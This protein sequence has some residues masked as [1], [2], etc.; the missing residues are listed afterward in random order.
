MNTICENNNIRYGYNYVALL[1]HFY[2][3]DRLLRFLLAVT[4]QNEND[5]ND[6]SNT[7]NYSG[8]DVRK[9]MSDSD[10]TASG[11]DS[12]YQ[13]H[14]QQSDSKVYSLQEVSKEEKK[15]SRPLSLLPPTMQKGISVFGI[16]KINTFHDG[17]M[18]QQ[19]I[20][21]LLIQEVLIGATALSKTTTQN[22][23]QMNDSGNVMNMP[24]SF[25]EADSLRN[26]EKE[27]LRMF[28][29]E[30]N[31]FQEQSSQ[32]HFSHV[33]SQFSCVEMIEIEHLL[34]E[35]LITLRTLLPASKTIQ[36]ELSNVYITSALFTLLRIGSV[37]LQ[38]VVTTILE[39]CLP[40][41]TPDE[42][43]AAVT[44]DMDTSLSTTS[45][46]PL[47]FYPTKSKH[48]KN[49]KDYMHTSSDIGA[50]D[51]Q[52]DE[53]LQRPF[54]SSS[55]R[56]QRRMPD[57]VIRTLLTNIQNS[58]DIKSLS[59]Q[60]YNQS[61]A[62]YVKNIDHATRDTISIP[63]LQNIKE[64]NIRSF[65]Q[66]RITLESAER[67]ISLGKLL[68]SFYFYSYLGLHIIV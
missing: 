52:V 41:I 68:A 56:S 57:T 62:G 65:E 7:S 61:G 44:M 31:E 60:S 36:K 1:Y 47:T 23:Q 49:S 25:K 9:T 34:Y 45:S 29:E 38:K 46:F 5:S 48:S 27:Q 43:E 32:L 59:I 63:S 11:I 51:R 21:I 17:D 26:I 10:Y 50:S 33:V 66:G 20:A 2:L 39:C 40:T 18:L 6:T 15:M 35:H 53:T 58:L 22:N 67:N 30:G 24:P 54:I 19:G 12:K 55:K 64:A 37:R 42:A 3:Y 4:C 8:E 14:Q 13:K 28:P 16:P